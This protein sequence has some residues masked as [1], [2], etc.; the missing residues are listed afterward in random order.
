MILGTPFRQQTAVVVLQ[1][2]GE[3][4]PL[5]VPVLV[6]EPDRIQRGLGQMPSQHLS[7]LRLVGAER[8][9]PPVYPAVPLGGEH[10]PLS[11]PGCSGLHT[12][13]VKNPLRRLLLRYLWHGVPS[14]WFS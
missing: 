6:T 3:R 12:F 11:C 7:R 5:V 2:F 9:R 10:D 14:G 8:D 13:S 1:V 4:L